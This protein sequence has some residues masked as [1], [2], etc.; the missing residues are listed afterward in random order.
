MK[1][2]FSSDY[3][4]DHQNILRYDNRPFATIDQMNEAI[5]KRH[6]S[7]VS[8]EDHFYFLG[9]FAFSKDKYR[10][11]QL[12]KRL[13]GKK[14]FIKG[15]HDYYDTIKLYERWGEY[16]GEQKT[17][18]IDTQWIVLNH[19]CLREWDRKHHGSW[20]LFGHTHHRLPYD[21]ENL[22]MDVGINGYDYYPVEFNEIKTYMNQKASEQ[23][24]KVY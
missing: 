16:L 24:T 5:I 1:H 18:K 13:N 4:F 2:F 12:L 10:I 23:K 17:I 6:N 3:H 11:E 7:Q 22:T 9:D 20:H 21:H 15:N 14:F 19:F 8:K